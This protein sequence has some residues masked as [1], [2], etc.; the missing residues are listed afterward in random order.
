MV[1]QLIINNPNLSKE[2]IRKILIQK[3]ENKEISIKKSS[4]YNIISQAFEILKSRK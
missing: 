4:I 2:K 1:T 3:I